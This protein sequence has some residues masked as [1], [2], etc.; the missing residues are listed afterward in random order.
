MT[1]NRNPPAGCPPEN[2]Q[3]KGQPGTPPFCPAQ[4][5]VP[6]GAFPRDGCFLLPDFLTHCQWYTHP[7]AS[8]P[9]GP[10][11]AAPPPARTVP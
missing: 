6:K 3:K 1:G 4:T 5:A 10:D 7:P 8:A 11:T 2:K 9:D